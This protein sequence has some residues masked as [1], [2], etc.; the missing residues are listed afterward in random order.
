MAF[1]TYVTWSEAQIDRIQPNTHVLW[2]AGHSQPQSLVNQ[3]QN[4][5]RALFK[6]KTKQAKHTHDYQQN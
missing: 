6:N 3:I 1:P 4:D 2:V 5:S